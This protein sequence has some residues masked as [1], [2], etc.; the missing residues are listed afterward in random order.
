MAGLYIHIPFCKSRCIYC[1]F[2][3][4]VEESTIPQYVD[5]L[6]REMELRPSPYIFNTV[7]FGGGTPSRLSIPFLKQIFN[8]IQSLYTVS[9]DAEITLECNPDDI[10]EDFAQSLRE[11]PVNRIS[12]GAQTFDNQRLAFLHRRHSAEQVKTAVA[13]LRHAGIRN[14][15]IDLIYGFP[16]E[17]L[18]EWDQDIRQVLQLDVEHISAYCLSVEEGTA[19]HQ[20]TTQGKVQP[21]DEEACLA[22]YYHLIDQLKDAGYTHYEISNFAKPGYH[23]R[24]NSSYWDG[25][26]Y[27]GIGAAAHSYDIQT[28]HWNVAD[29]HTYIQQ[30]KA[31]ILPVE[32]REVIDMPTRYNDYVMTSLRTQH[33]IDLHYIHQQFPATYTD[34]LQRQAERHLQCHLLEKEGHHLRLTKEALFISDSIISDLFYA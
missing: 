10:T 14:I 2:Y 4:T 29:L 33:G 12:M 3:S 5:A 1:G 13:R 20:L 24:H 9:D 23:S 26:P 8:K 34:Y 30:L 21:A 15:S 16:Q 19:L 7:Y 31:G 17:T 28:R 27:W 6:C 18:Q 11:L 25:T 32:E 22:M